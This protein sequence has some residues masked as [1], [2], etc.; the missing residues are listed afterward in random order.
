MSRSRRTPAEEASFDCA[1][2][3]PALSPKPATPQRARQ[4]WPYGS[5]RRDRA[6]KRKSPTVGM[7]FIG[8]DFRGGD[9]HYLAA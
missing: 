5:K 9:A 4:P 3:E 1:Q 6:G 8:H 2:D 7:I